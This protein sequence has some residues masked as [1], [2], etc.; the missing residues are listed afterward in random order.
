V[1]RLLDLL[2]HGCPLHTALR[3]TAYDDGARP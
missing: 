1:H 3:L 2:G